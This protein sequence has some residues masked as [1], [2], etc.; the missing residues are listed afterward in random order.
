MDFC[1]TP[2]NALHATAS[3]AA[4]LLGLKQAEHAGT[5]VYFVKG[6]A[7]AWY[8]LA[9]HARVLVIGECRTWTTPFTAD[10]KALLTALFKHAIDDSGAI[11]DKT[12]EAVILF[13]IDEETRVT[14]KVMN[15]PNGMLPFMN[16]H[17]YKDIVATPGAPPVTVRLLCEEGRFTPEIS[18]S[19]GKIKVY[20]RIGS[21]H[22]DVTEADFAI[23]VAALKAA[24]AAWIAAGKPGA[25]TTKKRMRM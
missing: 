7:S 22:K 23:I 11:P 25:K 21:P 3:A 6:A 16:A 20:V 14:Y 13:E 8:V 1:F 4:V 17:D 2:D 9:E 12:D 10:D 18:R 15:V 19:E 24:K 5:T